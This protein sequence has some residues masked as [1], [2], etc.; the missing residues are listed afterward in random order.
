MLN[1]PTVIK[2]GSTV[3]ATYTYLADGTKIKVVNALG[4]GFDYI[5]SFK[6]NR[7]N[8]NITL[9]SVASA[10]GRTYKTSS[11]YEARYFI[12][13]HLG[14]TRLATNSS[15]NVLEQND[16][17]PYGERHTNSALA[18]STNPYLYNGKESQKDFGINYIDSEARF[19]RLD[20]AFNS[21]DP[22]SEKYY[23]I[24]PYVYCGSNPIARID[25]NGLDWYSYQEKYLDANGIYQF[26]TRYKYIQGEMSQQEMDDGGYTHLGKTY[27][28][29]D[30]YF[31]LGGAQ[32][33]YDKSNAMSMFSLEK[34]IQADNAAIAAINT[35]EYV[36]EFWDKYNGFI[37]D[38]SSAATVLSKYIQLSNKYMNPIRK[39]GN[40]SFGINLINDYNKLV[41]GQLH[42]IDIV[43]A[44][45]NVISMFGS[46][47]AA[48]SLKYSGIKKS[49]GVLTNLEYQLR[50]QVNIMQKNYI[51]MMGGGF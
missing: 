15:G 6:Y 18:A 22:L 27:M 35:L 11:G 40:I 36:G 51:R 28:T 29:E 14:S 31:S 47:G 38:G 17:M 50:D 48:V 13:D 39:I 37:A 49:A 34:M 45:I 33:G 21:I 1:L 3:K 10:G 23:H 43:D 4:T 5:G 24:S 12:A 19:Q 46:Y 9:E 8:S 30:T 26:R 42:G 44:S 16:Y 20:G 41:N 2:Q 7:S 32:I 25:T